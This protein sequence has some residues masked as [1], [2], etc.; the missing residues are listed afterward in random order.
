[1]PCCLCRLMISSVISESM[2]LSAEDPECGSYEDL[3]CTWSPVLGLAIHTLEM[4][5]RETLFFF[6]FLGGDISARKACVKQCIIKFT[7]TGKSSVKFN[8]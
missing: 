6:F 8:F 5:W 4:E 1:M 7:A 3:Q 2:V